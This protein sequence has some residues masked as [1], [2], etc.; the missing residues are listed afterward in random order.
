MV[1][2]CDSKSLVAIPDAL[3]SEFRDD[4]L[5]KLCQIKSNGSSFLDLADIG[6]FV[7]VIC[8]LPDCDIDVVTRVIGIFM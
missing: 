1:G 5:L 4:F 7:F 6:E 2:V 3:T 8:Y